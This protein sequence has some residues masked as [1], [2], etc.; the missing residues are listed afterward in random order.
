MPSVGMRIETTKIQVREMQ[1][2]LRKCEAMQ[3]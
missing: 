3:A 1:K 2:I